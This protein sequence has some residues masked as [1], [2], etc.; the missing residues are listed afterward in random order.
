MTL[1]SYKISRDYGFAPNP[2]FGFC[3]VACCKPKIRRRAVA[4]DLVV[5]CGSTALKKPAQLIYAMRVTEKL[6]FEEYWADL[7]FRKKRP[8]FYSGVAHL[9][10]DNIYHKGANGNW[11]QEDSHH[12]FAN[13]DENNLNSTR[14]LGANAV[15]IS[16]DFVYYGNNAPIIPELFRN[17]D[18]DDLY[19]TV[20]DFRNSYS[21]KFESAFSE[22]F[23]AQ[24]KG[25]LG[26]PSSWK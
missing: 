19:P 22:W 4:G 3:T 5:G 21:D 1:W 25:R 12:S 13:G 15:L 11:K 16:A 20:R 18:G 9:Y 24:P 8:N 7:R 10:G 6:T 14:D 23:D 17:L 2:F 26:R